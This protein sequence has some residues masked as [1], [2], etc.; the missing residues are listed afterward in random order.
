MENLA[1]TTSLLST[2]KY[3]KPKITENIPLQFNN[4]T[5]PKKL[6]SFNLQ[7]GRH[8]FY[9]KG[10]F[11]LSAAFVTR[12]FPLDLPTSTVAM[13]TPVPIICFRP[14]HARMYW[15]ML[16]FINDVSYGV[17]KVACVKKLF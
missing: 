2:L 1:R 3:S 10:N 13:E 5:Y 15:I 9:E 6:P 4:S 14:Q 17:H 7:C 12:F 8:V 11:Q 16:A